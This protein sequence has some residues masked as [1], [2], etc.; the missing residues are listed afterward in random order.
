ILFNILMTV[1]ILILYFIAGAVAVG[2]SM[3]R[4]GTASAGAGIFGLLLMLLVWG[5]ALIALILDIVCMIKAYQGQ[6]WK[7]PVVGNFAESKA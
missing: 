5:L 3:D 1:V 6:I 7:L 2:S 4:T